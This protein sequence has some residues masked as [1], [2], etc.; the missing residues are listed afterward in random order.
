VPFEITPEMIALVA[1]SVAATVA[2][3]KGQQAYKKKKNGENKGPTQ[4]PPHYKL[5]TTDQHEKLCLDRLKPLHDDV[6]DISTRMDAGFLELR[7]DVKE[8][9]KNGRK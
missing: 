7:T 2:A 4:Y 1:S 6:K 9:L 5:L 8:I 3:L